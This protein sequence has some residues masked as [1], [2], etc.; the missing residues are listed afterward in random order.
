M[1]VTWAPPFPC[2]YLSFRLHFCP[3]FLPAFV[4]G[5]PLFLL[6]YVPGFLRPHPVTLDS[7][8][9]L[10]MGFRGVSLH[11]LLWLD[12]RP[13]APRGGMSCGEIFALRVRTR[14]GWTTTPRGRSGRSQLT[15]PVARSES[16]LVGGALGPLNLSLL[17]I[18]RGPLNLERLHSWLSSGVGLFLTRI[19]SRECPNGARWGDFTPR[20]DCESRSG[21]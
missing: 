2:Y 3:P 11:N 15:C 19:V 6:T 8:P 10:W 21:S 7:L 14:A 5:I 16:G 1:P 9:Q 13:R 18:P 20:L 4:N 12:H 17:L